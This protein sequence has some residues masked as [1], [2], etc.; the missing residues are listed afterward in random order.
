ML[1]LAEINQFVTF[2]NQATQ[3]QLW[4]WFSAQVYV[5]MLKKERDSLIVR[6]NQCFDLHKVAA[7]C[8]GYQRYA[9]G[10]GQPADFPVL[11]CVR[12]C[13]CAISAAGRCA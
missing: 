8:K 6:V 12:R 9:G 1:T 5:L 7:A 10:A 11:R 3:E 2:H 4:E 13:C